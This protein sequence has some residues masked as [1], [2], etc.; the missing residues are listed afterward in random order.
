MLIKLRGLFS[1]LA[2]ISY[3]NEYAGRLRIGETRVIDVEVERRRAP[4]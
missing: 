4:E 1:L 3:C 2:I